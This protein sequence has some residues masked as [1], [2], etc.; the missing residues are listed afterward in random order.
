MADYFNFLFINRKMPS[1]YHE[2]CGKPGPKSNEYLPPPEARYFKSRSAP[3]SPLMGER[4]S[5]IPNRGSPRLAREVSRLSEK[6]P[7]GKDAR[8]PRVGRSKSFHGKGMYA[9]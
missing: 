6:V 7:P 5:A 1:V 9:K 4:K 8:S 2:H 3:N